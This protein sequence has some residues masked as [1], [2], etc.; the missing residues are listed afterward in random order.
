MVKRLLVKFEERGCPVNFIDRLQQKLLITNKT[1]GMATK[2]KFIAKESHEQERHGVEETYMRE[3]TSC[4]FPYGR[5]AMG[6]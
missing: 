6:G 1:K 4:Q 3:R 2:Q 5:R